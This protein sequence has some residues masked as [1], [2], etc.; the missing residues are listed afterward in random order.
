M[1]EFLA[2]LS[3]SPWSVI[4]LL[5]W[6]ASVFVVVKGW[7]QFRGLPL[8]TRWT[9]RCCLLVGE[10]LF[11]LLVVLVVSHTGCAVLVRKQSLCSSNLRFLG[12]ALSFSHDWDERFPPAAQWGDAIVGSYLPQVLRSQPDQHPLPPE[13][14]FRCPSARSPFGYAFNAALDKMLFSK[15]VMPQETVLL[16][17]SDALVRNAAGD[18]TSLPPTPRHSDGDNYGFA[19]GHVRWFLRHRASQLRWNP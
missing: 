17:E 11:T 6:V 16:F 19:D 12:T 15:I 2:S 18:Q 3:H 9:G 4:L 7:R 14:I 8:P 13:Q 1:D 10:G 5:A